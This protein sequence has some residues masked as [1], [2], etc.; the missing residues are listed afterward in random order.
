M[1]VILGLG[2]GLAVRPGGS[3]KPAVHVSSFAAGLTSEPTLVEHEGAQ[4]CVELR[5]TPLGAF[6]LLGVPMSQLTGRVV[7]LTDLWGRQADELVE[8]LVEVPD[9]DSRFR[10]LD[11]HLLRRAVEG[12]RPAPELVAAW[13]RLDRHHGDLA[14]GE[15][16]RD[17]GWSRRLLAK[18]FREQVGLPPKETARV[19]R[20]AR[21]AEL[22]GHPEQY[23]LAAIAAHCGFYDQAHLNRDFRALADCTPTEYRAAHLLPALPGTGAQPGA[24]AAHS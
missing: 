22:V 7:E 3:G 10:L 9:W 14:I 17:T 19:L 11:D 12:C 2:Q 5:L 1:V 20:F 18:R 4:R 24:R 21:A 8:R 23:A 16:I 15:L 13:T 6:R